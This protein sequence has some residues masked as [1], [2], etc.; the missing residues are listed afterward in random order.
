MAGEI[1]AASSIREAI[2]SDQFN[3]VRTVTCAHCWHRFRPARILWVAQHEDLAGDPVLK[4]EPLRFLPTRFN[5]EGMAIDGRGMVCNTMA[6]PQCHLHIPR[7]LLENGAGAELTVRIG[8]M[9]AGVAS[10]TAGVPASA[11]LPMP[12]WARVTGG[13]R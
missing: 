6:C 7:V 1:T 9:P 13:G 4:D 12:S 10:I 5:L 11:G 8:E 2:A 3:V